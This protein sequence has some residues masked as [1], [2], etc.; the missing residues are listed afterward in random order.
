MTMCDNRVEYT[1]PKGYDYVTLS[2]KCGNTGI[3]GEAVL[4][5]E[6]SKKV[7]SGAM[8]RPGYCIHGT[9]LTDY[10]CDCIQCEM[11]EPDE[12]VR[13][14]CQHCGKDTPDAI[15]VE[16]EGMCSNECC[17]EFDRRMHDDSYLHITDGR[18]I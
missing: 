11:G 1:V 4:C 3:D 12:P 17:T 9:R 13:T 5:R 2:Y 14:T 8:A 18:L 16:Y 10:D 6:C 15:L 7:D